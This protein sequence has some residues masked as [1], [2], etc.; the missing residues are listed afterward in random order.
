MDELI[1]LIRPGKKFRMAFGE[2]NVNNKTIHICAII[3]EDKVVYKYWG[4]IKQRW[5]YVIED[6]SFLELIYKN[7]HMHNVR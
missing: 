2:N 6:I 5:F 1:K 4:K 3:D 7:G